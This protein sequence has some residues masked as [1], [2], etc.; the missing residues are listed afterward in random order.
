LVDFNERTISDDWDS[1]SF[2]NDWVELHELSFLL[3][4]VDWSDSGWNGNCYQYSETLNPCC[5]SVGTVCNTDF[6]CDWDNTGHHK[7][8]QGEVLKGLAKEFKE[9]WWLFE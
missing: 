3:V 1:F 9:P 5:R 2:I 4:I 7:D 6:D 8:S